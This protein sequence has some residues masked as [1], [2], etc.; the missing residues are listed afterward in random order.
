[1]M[2]LPK[3]TE[4]ELK[5]KLRMRDILMIL[6]GVAGL[7]LKRWLSFTV[8]DFVYSYVGNVTISYAVFFLTNIAAENRLNR[9]KIVLISLA[10]VEIFE[11]TNGFGFMTNVYDPFDY[12]ANAL[13]ISLAFIVD[14][15]ST[16][17]ILVRSS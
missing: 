9:F 12:L 13:G 2:P 4:P 7:L 16:R 17:I 3:I 10:V 5:L 1:M 8:S 14:M 15:I 6:A 11:L